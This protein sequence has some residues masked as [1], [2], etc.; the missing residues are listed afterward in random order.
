MVESPKKR[1]QGDF[2]TNIAL[3]GAKELKVSPGNWLTS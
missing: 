3:V 1:S 2:S